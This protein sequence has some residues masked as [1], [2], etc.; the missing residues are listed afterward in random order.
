[1]SKRAHCGV[2]Q[3]LRFKGLGFTDKWNHHIANHEGMWEAY[4]DQGDVVVDCGTTMPNQ[5]Y[6]PRV[7]RTLL[8]YYR[9]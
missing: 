2:W 9:T 4:D 7:V 3:V 8:V 1:M 5:G 6:P